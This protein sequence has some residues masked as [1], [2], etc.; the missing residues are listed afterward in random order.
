MASTEP[1]IV[2]PAELADVPELLGLMRALAEFEGY[3]DAFTV[4]EASLARAGFE[5]GIPE[6]EAFV[7]C[8]CIDDRV[9]GM[10]VTHVIRWTYDLAPTL[11][12]KELYVAPEARERGTGTA[13]MRAVARHAVGM[14]AQRLRWTVIP[15]NIAAKR[16]YEKLGARTETEWEPWI[17]EGDAISRLSKDRRTGVSE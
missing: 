3:L 17:L 9:I 7:A 2:R 4:D 11:V 1:V 13:L 15:A 14:G 6:F 8:S 16:F 12:L 10:A 5:T